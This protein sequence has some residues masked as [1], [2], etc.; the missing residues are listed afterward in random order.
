MTFCVAQ[1]R[2]ALRFK[3]RLGEVG[4]RLSH[5]DDCRPARIPDAARRERA[6]M[7][8]FHAATLQDAD[9]LLH[10]LQLRGRL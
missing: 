7:I 3:Q 2:V 8:N 5:P 4:V 10:R 1:I 6:R 9:Q